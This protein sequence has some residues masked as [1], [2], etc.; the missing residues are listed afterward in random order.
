MKSRCSN[1][2]LNQNYRMIYSYLRN[3]KVPIKLMLDN[4]SKE[5]GNL[6]G[7]ATTL[8]KKAIVYLITLIFRQYS[9]SL[10]T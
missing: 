5:S 4:S 10:A 2:I 7:K 9:I 8:V 3:Y 6:E 1:D